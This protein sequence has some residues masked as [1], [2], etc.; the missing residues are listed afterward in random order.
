MT[1]QDII[2]SLSDISDI[3][4]NVN[5]KDKDS[6]DQSLLDMGYF[7]I[8]N[9]PNKHFRFINLLDSVH[10]E[11]K[12]LLATLIDIHSK[13]KKI[14]RKTPEFVKDS[15]NAD[16][17]D[18]SLAY[19]INDETINMRGNYLFTVAGYCLNLRTKPPKHP[20]LE[21][22]FMPK[23]LMDLL[24]SEQLSEGLVLI[25]ADMGKGKTT[26]AVATLTSRLR[27]FGGHAMALEDPSEYDIHG[28][29]GDYGFCSQSDVK[30]DYQSY[31]KSALRKYPTTDG[32]ILYFGEIRD[33]ESAAMALLASSQ[34]CL[35][36][37]TIHGLDIKATFKRLLT[38][39]ASK[40]NGS[41]KVAADM[42]ASSFRFIFNQNKTLNP[43]GEGWKK[44]YIDG[45]IFYALNSDTRNQVAGALTDGKFEAITTLMSRQNTLC[46]KYNEGKLTLEDLVNVKQ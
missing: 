35:V 28:F 45:D 15:E 3:Y 26:T 40:N 1:E 44:F 16:Q 5:D 23:A 33:P 25:T 39:V 4:F 20:Y 22:L 19:D 46:E 8:L 12:E 32:K 34:G 43:R 38:F 7:T 31:M 18:F 36:I 11:N 37:S 29:H 27:K 9:E 17:I 21:D 14:I 30:G 24:L 13:A 41:T 10:N 6:I 2:F 42:L